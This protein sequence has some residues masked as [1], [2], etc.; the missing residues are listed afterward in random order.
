MTDAVEE[1]PKATRTPRATKVE[2]PLNIV[3]IISKVSKEAGG[4]PSTQKAGS[5]IKFPYRS[6]DEV[7]NHLKEKLDEHGVIYA[8][9]LLNR[10][11]TSREV[12]AGKVITQ[13][14][15]D[16]EYTFYAPDGSTLVASAPG[17]AQD[18]ADRSGAQAMSVSLR[19]VLIQVFKLQANGDPEAA[20]E[21]VQK[22]IA[23]AQKTAAPGTKS[24]GPVGPTAAQLRD[25]IA[26]LIKAGT[27]DGGTVNGLGNKIAKADNP[28]AWMGDAKVL[29]EV[30][31]AVKAGEVA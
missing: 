23:E 10:V 31:K 4:L 17:L 8:P 22:Y 6:V 13:S 25:E 27:T 26:E 30:V 21:D 20:G 19:T 28:S 24:P 1:K 15:L 16:V 11:T 5:G 29:A 7:V 18:Y 3:Q 9:R 14:D 12:G 2:E